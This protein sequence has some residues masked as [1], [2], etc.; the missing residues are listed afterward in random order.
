MR[1]SATRK[2]IK[3]I[4]CST[5]YLE[6]ILSSCT[7]IAGEKSSKHRDAESVCVCVHVAAAASLMKNHFL[8]CKGKPEYC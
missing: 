6:H 4:Q 1:E 7:V 5:S 3:N 8:V 2:L